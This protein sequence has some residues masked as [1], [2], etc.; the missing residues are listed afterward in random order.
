MKLFLSLSVI[1]SLFARA[2]IAS[3]LSIPMNFEYLALNGKVIETNAFNHQSELT[4]TPGI[5][6]IA[7]RYSDM[8]PDDYSDSQSFIKSAPFIISLKAEKQG[9]YQLIPQNGSVKD[10]K[11]FA[12]TPK[13][14]ILIN[15]QQADYQVQGTNLKESSFFSKL[16]GN[17]IDIAQAAA[18]ATLAS[19]TSSTAHMQ[20]SRG[21]SQAN[22]ATHAEQMLQYWWL[23]ADEQTRKTFMTWAIKDL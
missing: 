4:L 19:N 15:G 12:K 13:V 18:A 3:S 16:Q 21:N 20:Q 8:V 17:G 10:P 22:S 6:N 9:N 1:L 5:N 23:Q 14:E 7:I 2:A 11:Q